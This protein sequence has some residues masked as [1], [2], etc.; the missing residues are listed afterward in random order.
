MKNSP[1]A[2]AV[3]LVFLLMV[4]ANVLAH[5]FLDHSDPKVG[6]VVAKP[7]SE[8]KLWFTEEIE[9]DFSTIEVD[10]SNGKRIDKQDA[11]QDSS[12]K[13]LLIVSIPA[14]PGGEYTV[15]WKV[16]STDTHHTHGSFKFTVKTQK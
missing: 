4:P 7:P 11:Y 9:P 1:I 16:V 13:K 14:L 3:C 12:D 15:N 10:D 5:A 6:S 8:I 2:I